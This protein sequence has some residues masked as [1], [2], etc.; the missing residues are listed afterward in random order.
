MVIIAPCQVRLP[1]QF[2]PF[3]HILPHIVHLEDFENI[4]LQVIK[5]WPRRAFLSRFFSQK[6][7][8]DDPWLFFSDT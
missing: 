3:Q 5:I 1:R 7:P 6:F 2:Y 4:Y 8:N